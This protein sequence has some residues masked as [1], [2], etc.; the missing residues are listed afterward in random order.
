MGRHIFH[1][2]GA[3]ALVLTQAGTVP[4]Q[5][6]TG[7]ARVDPAESG[8]RETAG[9]LTVELALSQ[10]VPWRV[11]TLDAPPRAVFDFREVDWSGL[12]GGAFG[13]GVRFGGY[14][15]GWSRLVVDLHGPL[16]LDRAGLQVDAETGR[17]RLVARFAEV[18]AER[19]AALSGAPEDAGPWDEATAEAVPAPDAPM[20]VVIDAG[21]GGIDPGAEREGLVEKDLM[22]T[23]AR[24]LSDV[25]I[26]AGNVDVVLTRPDDSF[27]SLER[28]VELAHEVG[29]DVFL[30]LHADALSEGGA[31]GAVVYTLSQT[32]SDEASEKLAERHDRDDLLS[33]VDLTGKDD[34]VAGVLMDLART[35]TRPRTHRLADALVAAFR[36]SGAPVNSHV[37]RSAGF[38]VLKAPDI[39]SVLIEVGFLSDKRDRTNIAD[40]AFR[41]RV[42]AAIRDALA[43]WA[44]EDEALAPLL[45]Q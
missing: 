39:P 10:G 24:E 5:D 7:L 8:L 42:A 38:S 9:G 4:A 14:R 1:I 37:R 36:A 13:D 33:G 44:L 34:V 20:V 28:R 27:V 18:G 11:F 43:A 12:A 35:E 6:F 22:L 40:R 15:P 2:L 41:A 45:R 26:R 30:S 3:L 23:F 17:A 29:A 25:L 21:H 16:A 31:R 32:A 19:F